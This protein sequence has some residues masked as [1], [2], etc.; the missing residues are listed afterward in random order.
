MAY[1]GDTTDPLENMINQRRGLNRMLLL[2]AL[3][4]VVPALFQSG[5]SMFQRLSSQ[6]PGTSAP[7]TTTAAP[8][9][10]VARGTSR[11]SAG[12]T[13]MSAADLEQLLRS[14]PASR[15][16]PRDVRC[17]PTNTGWDYVC[18]YQTDVPHRRTPMKIGV[19]V[20]A[21]AIVQASAPHPLGSRLATP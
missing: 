11:I 18:M 17:T 14:A 2:G 19:R 15:Q 8:P 5:L 9:A 12:G 16:A 21:N 20:S 4:F 7:P 13:K 1:R 3:F 10:T 6:T